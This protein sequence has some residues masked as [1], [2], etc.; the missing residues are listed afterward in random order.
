MEPTERNCENSRTNNHTE[1][2]EVTAI[3]PT[4]IKNT[5]HDVP[6]NNKPLRD[7]V[8]KVTLPSIPTPNVFKKQSTIVEEEETYRRLQREKYRYLMSPRSRFYFP[9]VK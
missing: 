8:D 2:V 6:N 5:Q 7:Q 9:Y 1:A 3:Q 4:S